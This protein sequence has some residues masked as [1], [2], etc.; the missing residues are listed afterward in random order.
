MAGIIFAMSPKRGIMH[1]NC[2]SEVLQQA[3]LRLGD[4]PKC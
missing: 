2:N 1:R 3:E 4:F